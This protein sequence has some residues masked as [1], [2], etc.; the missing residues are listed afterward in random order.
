MHYAANLSIHFLDDRKPHYQVE[1]VDA[2]YTGDIA[3]IKRCEHLWVAGLRLFLVYF[4][5]PPTYF[6]V[7]FHGLPTSQMADGNRFVILFE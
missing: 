4:F 5:S 2:D 3:T 6:I 7:S 1:D